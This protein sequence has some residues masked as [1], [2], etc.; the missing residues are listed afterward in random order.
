MT[1]ASP[2]AADTPRGDVPAPPPSRGECLLVTALFL[3]GLGFRAGCPSGLAVEH[4]DEGVY[5]S[6]LWFGAA[7]N[8]QYP[9]QYLYAPP[10]LPRLIEWIF[11]LFGPS[12]GAAMASSIAAGSLTVLLVWRVGRAWFG[13]SA[14]LAAASLAAFSD[15]HLLYSRTALTDVLLCFWLLAAL[16]FVRNAL[17]SGRPALIV[18]AGAATGL[19]WWTKYNGWLPAAIGLAGLVPFLVTDRSRIDSPWRLVSR[20]LLVALCA[21]LVWLPCLWELEPHGGYAAV[22]RN[23]R[24]YL[25]GW[26]GWSNSLTQQLHHQRVLAG[27][28]SVVGCCLAGLIA[29]RVFCRDGSRFT[30]NGLHSAANPDLLPDAVPLAPARFTWNRPLTAF[31]KFALLALLVAGGVLGPAV[32]TALAAAAG[33]GLTVWNGW[34]HAEAVPRDVALAGWLLAAWWLGLL[35]STPLYVPYPRL[36]LPWM[37]ACWLGAG[38]AAGWVSA[39][40]KS[41]GAR[42]FAILCVLTGGASLVG[43]LWLRPAPAAAFPGWQP[44][45][46][47]AEV[48]PDIVRDACRDARL[49]PG[50]QRHELAVYVYGEPALLF[51]L[52]LAG[53]EHVV[54]VMHLAF[55]RPDAGPP[56]LPTFVAV[57]PHALQTYGFQDQ[58]AAGRQRLRH[59]GTYRFQPSDLVRLDNPVQETSRGK[60]TPGDQQ[61]DLYRVGDGDSP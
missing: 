33:I 58:F 10:L 57:G 20:W 56:Q 31:P 38:A 55:A 37:V 23:H 50:T 15:M 28:L 16:G 43:G 45:T 7:Q 12:N 49:D 60:R 5:A 47:M 48:A 52:R 6:N 14:G 13:P 32:L 61:I 19:A 8:Y 53:L 21:F 2:T 51:Q 17:L 54:P 40:L 39:N 26:E 42:R 35:V 29:G 1:T 27:W 34:R 4:F 3:A 41:A 36:T 59:V 11:V 18:A 30:W 25:V 46:A 22:A 24:G 44:R 9:N